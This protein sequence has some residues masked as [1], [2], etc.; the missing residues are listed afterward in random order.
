MKYLDIELMNKVCDFK[1][2]NRQEDK[3]KWQDSLE[4]Y[5]SYLESIKSR[6]SKRFFLFYTKVGMHDSILIKFNIIKR[7]LANKTCIDVFTLWEKSDKQFSLIFKDVKSINTNINLFDGYCEFGD[8]L[9]GE[10]LPVDKKLLSFEFLFYD[11]CNSIKIVF[12]KV[13]YNTIK[14]KKNN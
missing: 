11:S 2:N 3:L 6:F 8:Y 10:F 14:S 12:S 13:C 7:H 5:D 1:N 9:I 4:I